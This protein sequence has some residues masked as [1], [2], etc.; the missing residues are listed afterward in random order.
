MASMYSCSWISHADN[1][2]LSLSLSLFLPFCYH[3]LIESADII[4]SEHSHQYLPYAFVLGT[5]MIIVS[6][7]FSPLLTHYNCLW[8]SVLFSLYPAII[9]TSVA[10]MA[11]RHS[12]SSISHADIILLSLFFLTLNVA[13][14]SWDHIRSQSPSLTHLNVISGHNAITITM[15]FL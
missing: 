2:L 4:R 15:A 9:T 12:W 8:T 14:T 13:V 7:I 10:M 1:L 11:S 6:F 5:S 3:I